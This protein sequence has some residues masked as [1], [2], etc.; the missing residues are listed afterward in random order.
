[1][2]AAGIP[3]FGGSILGSAANFAVLG[4]STVTN[5]GATTLNGNLGLYPGTSITGA[6]SITVSGVTYINDGV[7]QTA[8]SDAL[9]GFNSLAAMAS[10]MTLTGDVLG[11]GGT[12]LTL[13]PGIYF[14]ASSAQLTGAL[15]LNFEGLSN[16]TIL[17]QIGSALTT[18][19]GSSV[20]IINPGA[21]DSVYWV[22]G[23]SAT[24]G[25]T[26]SFVGNIIADQS[27]TLNNSATD[28]CGSII[29][30]TGAVTMDTNTVTA[31]CSSSSATSTPEPG[32]WGLVGLGLL[33]GA[34]ALQRKPI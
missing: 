22:V 27:V 14:Y 32:S 4:A 21:N 25:T 8:Q 1:M 10:T 12:I 30:L 26:T 16:Q 19:S 2:A 29:A 33:A 9:T 18:A 34:L 7:A 23:S 13:T 15:T 6:G 11:S 20:L 17:F 24:L 5:T 31:G 28:S 3:A